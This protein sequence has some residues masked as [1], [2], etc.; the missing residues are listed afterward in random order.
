MIP[1]NFHTHTTYCDGKNTPRELIE[2]AIKL[3]CRE[4]GLSGHSYTFFDSDFCMSEENAKKYIDEVRRLK[5]EYKD[6]IKVFLGTEHDI[7][8]TYPRNDFDYCICSAHY[9]YKDGEYLCIDDTKELQEKII[10]EHFDGDKYALAECYFEA[11][12]RANELCDAKI[13]GHFDL[14]TKFNLFDTANQRYEKAVDCALENLL[15]NNCIFEVNTGGMAR[16][17]RKDTYP[18]R[19]IVEKIKKLGGR[20]IYTSDAHKKEN[21]LFGLPEYDNYEVLKELIG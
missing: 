9:V 18:E 7:F 4:I 8:S 5:T 17:Y 20:M 3:G 1:S 19:R 12:G 15:K 10:A 2:E 16:G 14:I 11:L 6:K 21:L 13:I